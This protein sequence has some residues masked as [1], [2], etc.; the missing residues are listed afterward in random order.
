[1][2]RIAVLVAKHQD[3]DAALVLAIDDGVGEAD[4]RIGPA[5]WF[6]WR[7]EGWILLKEFRDALELVQKRLAMPMP[8]SRW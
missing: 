2:F 3:P 4:Q 8:A 6:V 1:M 7:A 5:P